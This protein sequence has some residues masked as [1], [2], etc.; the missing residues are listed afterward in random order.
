MKLRTK[1]TSDCLPSDPSSAG[2]YNYESKGKKEFP[3]PLS[4]HAA[5]I[6]KESWTRCFSNAVKKHMTK[7]THR[8]KSL[9]GIVFQRDESISIMGKQ[10]WQLKVHILNHKQGAES[11]PVHYGFWNLKDSFTDTLLPARLH[12]L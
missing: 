2:R 12:S 7:I 6:S 1:A 9:F 10:S 3:G 4:L 8:R 11:K 5:C